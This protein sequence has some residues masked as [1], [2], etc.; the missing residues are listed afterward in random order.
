MAVLPLIYGVAV[1]FAAIAVLIALCVIGMRIVR[2]QRAA[3]HARRKERLVRAI[4]VAI[5]LPEAPADVLRRIRAHPAIA[6][7]IFEELGE[8][9][10]GGSRTR[11]VTLGRAAGLDTWLQAGLARGR[12]LERRLAAE[13]L[14]LFGDEPSCA[15]LRQAIDDPDA[16]VR[17]AA[18]LSLA[19]LGHAPAVAVLVTRL[20]G[21]SGRHS[22][23]LRR[24]FRL[25][26][27]Q[28][29]HDVVRIAEG[30]LGT[31]DLR[32]F[33]I[34]ALASTGEN[35]HSALLRV[36]TFDPDLEVRTASLAGLATLGQPDVADIVRDAM[37]DEAWQVRVAAINAARRLELSDLVPEIIR[38]LDDE[39]WWVSFRA[40]EALA[41]LGE[42]GLKALRTLALSE[43]E[44]RGRMASVVMAERGI[45]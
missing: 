8:V 11:L 43:V 45:A 18:G 25:I 41:A 37:S 33:A 23:L 22:L 26:V 9:I 38:C 13:V 36:L 12:P 10:R 17:L 27:A 1:F 15:A 2:T 32:P 20:A 29:P 30:K 34:D 4:M 21:S 24:L 31:P 19:E 42:S 40:A 6:R 5:E 3:R 39:I 14:R 28:E 7:D 35:E 16:D 44:R